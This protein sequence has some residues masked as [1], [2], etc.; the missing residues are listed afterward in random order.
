MTSV[1]SNMLEIVIVIVQVV[2]KNGIGNK[3]LNPV[4]GKNKYVIYKFS[5]A[6]FALVIRLEFIS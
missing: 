1:Y 2:T 3:Q 5:V 4:Q 6:L